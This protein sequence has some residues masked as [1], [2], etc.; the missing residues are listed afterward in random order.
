[1]P[2]AIST[3]YWH[4]ACDNLHPCDGDIVSVTVCYGDMF[5]TVLILIVIPC[6]S[7]CEM[8]IFYL[9]LYMCVMVIL[10]LSP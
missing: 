3:H 5:V 8:V 2:D 7:L 10:C 9:S 1:M 6:P 4:G